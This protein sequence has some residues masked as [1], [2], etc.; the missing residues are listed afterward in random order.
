MDCLYSNFDNSICLCLIPE[1]I[2]DFFSR[3]KICSVQSCTLAD[4]EF[5]PIYLGYFFV[6]L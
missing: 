4:N 1:V 3:E 6:A 5:L 2:Y